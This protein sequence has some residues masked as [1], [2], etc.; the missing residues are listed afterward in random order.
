MFKQFVD[1]IV[2]IPVGVEFGTYEEMADDFK[3]AFGYVGENPGCCTNGECICQ[4]DDEGQW[5]G[6]WIDSSYYKENGGSPDGTLADTMAHETMH[7]FLDVCSIIDNDGMVSIDND[8]PEHWTYHFGKLFSYVY[9]VVADGLSGIRKKVKAVDKKSEAVLSRIAGRMGK[10]CGNRDMSRVSEIFSSMRRFED[11]RGRYDFV[12]GAC[13]GLRKWLS[14][15]VGEKFGMWG[16]YVDSITGSKRFSDFLDSHIHD[17]KPC[18][19]SGKALCSSD[20]DGLMESVISKCVP[21]DKG[22]VAYKRF[23]SASHV[24]EYT[25]K[26]KETL[27]VDD[28][29]TA[30]FIYPTTGAKPFS[31]DI[32]KV[33]NDNLVEVVIDQKLPCG[34]NMGIEV[35]DDVVLLGG[36][37][38]DSNYEPRKN[39]VVSLP[40]ELVS[41][42]S[43]GYIVSNGDGVNDDFMKEIVSLGWTAGP[44]NG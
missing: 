29:V 16:Y 6:I 3:K 23:K 30:Y 5:I 41:N 31:A 33:V 42:Y 43:I 11:A 18:Y 9:E 27:T 24:V 20:P 8:V 22:S 4:F 7:A 35:K 12:S 10:Y 28:S 14:E 44:H 40:L 34:F 17:G 2:D 1:P 26:V 21:F 38:D 19:D 25:E 15:G 13:D 36:G 32:M 37:I 39:V